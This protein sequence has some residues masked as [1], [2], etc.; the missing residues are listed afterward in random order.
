[1]GSPLAHVVDQI[2]PTP[3]L[4]S[5]ASTLRPISLK[6]LI[7]ARPIGPAPTMRTSTSTSIALCMTSIHSFVFDAASTNIATHRVIVRDET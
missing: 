1:M 5:T 6:D 2:P 7:A 3:G 4:L